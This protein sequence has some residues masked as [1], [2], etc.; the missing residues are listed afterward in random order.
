MNITKNEDN[1]REMKYQWLNYVPSIIFGLS[2]AGLVTAFALGHLPLTGFMLLDSIQTSVLFI[3][4]K[5]LLG[6]YVGEKALLAFFVSATS[7]Y[8][9]PKVFSMFDIGA[10]RTRYML[11]DHNRQLEVQV[12]TFKQE[13]TFYKGQV[14]AIRSMMT[15]KLSQN[16]KDVTEED[17]RIQRRYV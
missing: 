1:M 8:F 11:Q 16:N 5:L 7:A 4:H 3:D 13:A 15:N 14:S 17:R 2:M 10:L 12:E 9:G 6:L